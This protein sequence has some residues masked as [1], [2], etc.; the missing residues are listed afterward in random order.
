MIK[1]I[2]VI[3]FAK[4]LDMQ[5]ADLDGY[6]SDEA[7]GGNIKFSRED[8]SFDDLSQALSTRCS[9]STVHLTERSADTG[10]GQED[11]EE[12]AQLPNFIGA[13]TK[14]VIEDV[15]MSEHVEGA[16]PESIFK[17]RQRASK[18]TGKNRKSSKVKSKKGISPKSVSDGISPILLNEDEG[19]YQGPV[20]RARIGANE[21]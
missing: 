9:I 11:N 17:S 19:E 14:E 6:I 8:A 2:F 20:K 3:M 7:L 1:M 15:E 13:P 10:A 4:L 5:A 21:Y 12:D 18:K 16:V